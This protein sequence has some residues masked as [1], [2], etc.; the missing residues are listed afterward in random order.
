[1]FDSKLLFENSNYTLSRRYFWA[2]QVLKL[3]DREIED[4][5]TAYGQSLTDAVW[6]GEHKYIWPGVAEMGPKFNAWRQRMLSIRKD[7]DYEITQLHSVRSLNGR[8]QSDIHALRN[9]LFTGLAL[10]ESKRAVNDSGSMK[11]M[12]MLTLLFLPSTFV[13]SVGTILD[14]MWIILTLKQLLGTSY[15]DL[16]IQRS[17]MKAEHTWALA[18]L[19]AS[20]TVLLTLFGFP[21]MGTYL[22][23]FWVAYKDWVS[24]TIRYRSSEDAVQEVPPK[25]I[26]TSTDDAIIIRGG[27][28]VRKKYGKTMSEDEALPQG[29]RKLWLDRRDTQRGFTFWI[30][31]IFGFLT[32]ILSGVQL[33]LSISHLYVFR[34]GNML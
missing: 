16:D 22:S 33:V 19:T 11:R 17:H 5:V 23:R 20:S 3:M 15:F 10:E 28:E 14:F 2:N 18:I 34:K 4:M 25:Q 32:L 26:R 24:Y 8:L 31:F 27:L 30:V 12:T 13:A 6:K 1:M 9:E 29:I 21:D 7:F